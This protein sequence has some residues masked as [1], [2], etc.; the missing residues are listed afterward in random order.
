MKAKPKK[1]KATR[2]I[3]N[4]AIEPAAPATIQ[5]GEDAQLASKL[6]AQM[7]T[8]TSARVQQRMENKEVRFELLECYHT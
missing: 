8:R 5:L 1:A 3:M 7:S 2:P 6:A 4:V